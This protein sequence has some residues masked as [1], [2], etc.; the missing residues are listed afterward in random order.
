MC[1]EASPPHMPAQLHTIPALIP[2][3]AQGSCRKARRTERLGSRPN[4]FVH[5][6]KSLGDAEE[7]QDAALQVVT[8][9]WD[10]TA[11]KALFDDGSV[12]PQRMISSSST[13]R[14]SMS[15][16]SQL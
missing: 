7:L 10:G 9:S 11:A 14:L 13:R 16:P 15:Y 8:R 1:G 5:F 2:Q 6:R 3:L 4:P 12:V